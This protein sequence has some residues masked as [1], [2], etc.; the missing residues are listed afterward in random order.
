MLTIHQIARKTNKLR[1]SG[2]KYVRFTDFKKGYDSLGRGFVAS[3][4]F[5]THIV[6]PDG[7]VRKNET[8]HKYVTV[9]TFLNAKLQV[10]VSCSCSDFMYRWEVALNNKGAAEIE[11]SNGE[12]PT[13]TNPT[14]KTAMCKHAF[15]LYMK[16][17]DKLPPPK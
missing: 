5:S 2:A 3:A 17:K 16:I 8:R 4:S 12:Q 6:S 15:A 11:Y 14:L 9:I 7:Q 10:S 1:Q 13:T